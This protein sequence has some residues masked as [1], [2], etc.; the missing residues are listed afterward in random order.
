MKRDSH[1]KE[2]LQNRVPDT[3]IMHIQDTDNSEPEGCL[4][5]W[6]SAVEWRR[7]TG[8]ETEQQDI[9]WMKIQMEVDGQ[10]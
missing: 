3:E 6:A 9:R 4:R 7:D 2:L 10:N 1:V 8:Q 5:E